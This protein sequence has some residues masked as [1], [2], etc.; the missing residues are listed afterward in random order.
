MSDEQLHKTI[1]DY[2]RDFKPERIGLFG[3]YARG[4]N[5]EESDIDILIRF[6][7]TCTLFQLVRIENELSELIGRKVDLVTE[8]A[9]RNERI[10]KSIQKDLQVIFEV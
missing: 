5:T 3:S 9:I 1:V 7:E 10:R 6:Q 8:G 4:E 2:L